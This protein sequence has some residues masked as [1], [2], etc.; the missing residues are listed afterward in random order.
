MLEKRSSLFALIVIDKE[1]KSFVFYL[2][3]KPGDR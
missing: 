3:K 1:K 2:K